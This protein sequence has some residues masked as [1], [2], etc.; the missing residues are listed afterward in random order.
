[1]ATIGI[2][3]L[4]ATLLYGRLRSGSTLTVV[5]PAALRASHRRPPCS[6]SALLGFLLRGLVRPLPAAWALGNLLRVPRLAD[7][8]LPRPA[9][10]CFPTGCGRSPGCSPP[11]WGMNAIRESALGGSPWPDLA[12]CFALGARLR[13]ARASSSPSGCCAPRASAPR[14]RCRDLAAHLLRR[15]P[16]ELPRALRLAVALDLHPEPVVAPIFQILL[17]AYIGRSPAWSPTSSIVT[18]TRSSTPRSRACSP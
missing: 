17:F 7:R 12:L 9:R 18:E 16:D 8:R 10:R 14:S 1:M 13:R 2:Y 15:R 4:V 11:T 5:A 3:S 6:R